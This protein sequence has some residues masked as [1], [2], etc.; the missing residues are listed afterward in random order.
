MDDFAITQK[1]SWSGRFDCSGSYA[2]ETSWSSV[3]FFHRFRVCPD[4]IHL[5]E[6]HT[7]SVYLQPNLFCGL[8]DENPVAIEMLNKHYSISH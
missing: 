5:V 3:G 4:R 8:A 6:W 1:D 2:N 7:E